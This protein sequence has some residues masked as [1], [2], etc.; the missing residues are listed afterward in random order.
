MEVLCFGSGDLLFWRVNQQSSTC[1]RGLHLP[2]AW[3]SLSES[4][5][6]YPAC[7]QLSCT[8][9]LPILPLFLKSQ[10]YA[11]MQ[12]SYRRE[13]GVKRNGLETHNPEIWFPPQI[14]L[15]RLWS[16]AC[17]RVF[18][19]LLQHNLRRRRWRLWGRQDGWAVAWKGARSQRRASGVE[20]ARACELCPCIHLRACWEVNW[21]VQM[22]GGIS[23][24]CELGH[25][26]VALPCS[27]PLTQEKLRQEGEPHTPDTLL[28]GNLEKTPCASLGRHPALPYWAGN[29]T[30][31]P[32]RTSPWG[33]PLPSPSSQH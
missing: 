5:L 4:P 10:L 29:K 18:V 30:Q 20:G 11:P 14:P 23:D 2:A 24:L 15:P 31:D 26:L 6:L 27:A 32:R 28:P 21:E 25:W 22:D 7:S 12:P 16:S 13:L 19:P 9:Q 8:M 1:T 3:N 33:C 17:V